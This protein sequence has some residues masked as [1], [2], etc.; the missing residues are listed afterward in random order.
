MT[1]SLVLFSLAGVGFFYLQNLVF[2]PQVRLDFLALLIFFL[3]L[4]PSLPLALSL[5][6]ILGLLQDSYAA[7]PVG[8]HLGAALLL[9]ATARF[10]RRRLLLPRAGS[11]ILASLLALTLQE[12]W[13]QVI[14]VI[15]RFQ[16]PFTWDLVTYRG[17]EIMAT[18]ALAPLMYQLVRG[19]ERLLRLV[20]W[21]PLREASPSRPFS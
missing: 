6:L 3:G 12:A 16:S 20:G 19:L 13:F 9:V 18:A 14:I 4:R 10:C 15:L 11:Q 1:A 8:L 21:A 5:A 17:L 7:T 2:F